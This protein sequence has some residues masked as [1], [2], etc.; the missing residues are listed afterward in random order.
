MSQDTKQNQDIHDAETMAGASGGERGPDARVDDTQVFHRDDT[1]AYDSAALRAGAEQPGSGVE[2]DGMGASTADG[3][4][5]NP[6][7]TA[8]PRRR[9]WTELVA[10]AAIAAVVGS[11][12]TLGV[13]ALT[14]SGNTSSLSSITGT[15]STA[16]SPVT[17]AGQE[18]WS[19]IAAKASPSVVAI[20]VQS[21]QG[22]DQGSGVVWDAAGNIVTNNHVVAAAGAGGTVQV[23]LGANTTYEAK[24]VGTD[25]TTDLAVVRLVNP[26]S[27]LQPIG[28]AQADS[29]T[30]G[31]PVMA[32]GNPL[33][34]SGTV[35][36]GIVSA[37]NR[38]VT[39]QVVS[40]D[41][42]NAQPGLFQQQQSSGQ[43]VVTD[44][45]QTSAAINPGNSG[46]ALVDA[47]GNLVGINSSI[48][49]LS[50]GSGQAGSIGIGFAIPV[51]EVTT[52]VTQL[53]EG[54][55]V[56]H[57]TL[58]V[59][60]TDATVQQG[61]ATVSGAGVQQVVDGS[62]AAQAGLQ[63]G[64]VITAVDGRPIDGADGLVGAVRGLAVGTQVKLTVVNSSGSSRTVTAA[65]TGQA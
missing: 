34:L 2:A 25:P 14:D 65:L 51:A 43:Q 53:I 12:V 42:G 50:S 13:G 23:R 38:P 57:A 55:S 54:G 28:R 58:G 3:G 8:N 46:G 63:T 40:G 60:I 29:L 49:S 41:S 6:A 15:T 7:P 31:A 35:T 4:P 17:V 33:G 59:S 39:T 37:L 10:V 61:S 44:A 30:V 5:A 18:N 27:D 21:A 9:R 24:V 32:L 56:Q 36:T 1:N 16:P 52:V 45:I 64:D 48:A 62:A 47:A 20:S 11:G 19:Q 22:G 26:P